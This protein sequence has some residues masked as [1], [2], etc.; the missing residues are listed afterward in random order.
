MTTEDRLGLPKL[1]PYNHLRAD[2]IVAKGA[3]MIGQRAASRDQDSERSMKT[4]VNAFNA[5]YGTSLTEEQGWAFMVFL[6][7]SRASKGKK[8]ED[9]YVD[10]SAYFG[11]MGES[12]LR[13]QVME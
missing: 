11:L 8:T 1:N 13:D 7:L 5:M 2:E 3:S 12:A 4:T 10:G 9:D 6:K